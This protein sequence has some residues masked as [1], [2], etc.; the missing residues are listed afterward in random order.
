MEGRAEI[1]ADGRARKIKGEGRTEESQK[2]MPGTRLSKCTQPRQDAPADPGAVLPFR[3]RK[4]LDARLLDGEVL[5]LVQQPVG[6]GLGQG[7]AAGEHDVGEEVLAQVEI[8]AVDG[9]DDDLVHAGVLEPDDLRVEQDLG[10]AEALLPDLE[11]L[12]VRQHVVDPLALLPRV[13]RVEPFLLLLAR[14][15]GDVRRLLLDLPH[16]LLLG[17]RVEDVA[18][19]SEQ[20]L[21]VLGHVPAG[22]VDAPDAAGHG[23]SLVDRHRVRH[24]V[25]GVEHEPRRPA[26]CVQ[27]EDG[28]DG[29]VQRRHVEGLEEDLRR[30]LPVRARVQRSLREQ[31]GML[32]FLK[33]RRKRTRPEMS[34]AVMILV[35][36][37]GAIG[38]GVPEPT[39]AKRQ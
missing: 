39:H 14:V 6:K 31:D 16:N 27:R 5:E 29:R 33:R 22:H 32:C 3:R 28:L 26:G 34:A 12:A 19:L 13:R 37:E 10:R 24:A 7:G 11:P 36:E 2:K 38:E 4:D 18:G 8:G 1:R 25:S 17:A 9:V 30:R 21:Q 15:R 35:K 23:E 20:Q